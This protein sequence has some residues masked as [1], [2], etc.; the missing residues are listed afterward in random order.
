MSRL[1]EPHGGIPLNPLLLVGR[2]RDEM[3]ARAMRLPSV[4]VS[5][6]EQGDLMMLGIGGFSPLDG[7]MTEADWKRVCKDYR[8]RS[9][10]FWPIPITLSTDSAVARAAHF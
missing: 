5:S 7:F 1:V 4:M 6:R 3:R 2:E 9:N 10:L 8:L